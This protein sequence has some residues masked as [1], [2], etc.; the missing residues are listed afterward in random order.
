MSG[1]LVGIALTVGGCFTILGFYYFVRGY[2]T[3]K[4]PSTSGKAREVRSQ[5][6]SWGKAQ[7]IELLVEYEYSVNGRSYR[8]T[9]I[10]I[11][12]W[13]HIEPDVLG[14]RYTGST[15]AGWA[16]RDELGGE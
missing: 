11:G 7:Y 16:A 6:G 4:W 2:R 8:S 1:I 12:H 3:R 14:P 10:G 15:S 5:L 13:M 9:Q